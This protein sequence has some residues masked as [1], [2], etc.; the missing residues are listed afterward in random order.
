MRKAYTA[1]FVCYD[2]IIVEIKA[3]DKMEWQ[4]RIAALQ[5]SESDRA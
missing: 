3:L 2:K 5:L 1:D 4:R